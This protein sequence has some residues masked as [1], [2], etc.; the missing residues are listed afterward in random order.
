METDLFRLMQLLARIHSFVFYQASGCSTKPRDVLPSLAFIH[1]HQNFK[2]A[3]ATEENPAFI[4][5]IQQY[6]CLY[7]K[8][9]WDFKNKFKKHNCWVE[10]AAKFDIT[11]EAA[12]KDQ[13]YQ[14]GLKQISDEEKM[15]LW[16][17][18]E[19]LCQEFQ[20]NLKISNG[21]PP[22][23]IFCSDDGNMVDY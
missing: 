5:E 22:L 6:N 21:S 8:Y 7:Y 17:P 23:L 19:I 13:E 12:E 15:C 16:G 9:S 2:M 10:I 3:F 18:A 11:P 4:E 14:D 1:F 20:K